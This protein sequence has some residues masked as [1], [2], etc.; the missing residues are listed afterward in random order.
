MRLMTRANSKARMGGT[1]SMIKKDK[2]K[3]Q[4]VSPLHDLVIRV[5]SI[6]KDLNS[7]ADFFAVLPSSLQNTM[8]YRVTDKKLLRQRLEQIDGANHWR[9]IAEI[10]GKIVGDATM[11][12]E[13]FDW[14]RHV[15]E[16]RAVVDPQYSLI[17]I[18]T[19]L[20]KELAVRGD[21]AGIERLFTEVMKG[22]NKLIAALEQTGFVYEATRRKYAKDLQG[23]LHDVILMSNDLN[24]VWRSLAMHI[25]ELDTQPSR[26]MEGQY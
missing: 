18:E 26:T 17:D 19:A 9:L 23:R 4:R 3:I 16:V 6:S 25:E 14:T 20:F 12:R 24:K 22:Q 2:R 5:P 7:L 1:L 11:D 10:G 21:K 15:A 8:R 13:P